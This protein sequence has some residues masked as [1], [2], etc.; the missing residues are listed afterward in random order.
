MNQCFLQ[1]NTE[2]HWCSS[3]TEDTNWPPALS[4]KKTQKQTG[5]LKTTAL[6]SC[7]CELCKWLLAVVPEWRVCPRSAA[8]YLKERKVGSLQTACFFPQSALL[9]FCSKWTEWV[10]PSLF[11]LAAKLLTRNVFDQISNLEL[12]HIYLQALLCWKVNFM[13]NMTLLLPFFNIMMYCYN[14]ALLCTLVFALLRHRLCLIWCDFL[15]WIPILYSHLC[16][17]ATEDI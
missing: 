8:K 10:S 2:S 16:K 5:F 11:S 17:A 15:K 3:F 12:A 13:A 6:C 14:Y 9:R 7:S 4:S 1:V